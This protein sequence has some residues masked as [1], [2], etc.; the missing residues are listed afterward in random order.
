MHLVLVATIFK[1]LTKNDGSTFVHP[2][3]ETANVRQSSYSISEQS[4]TLTASA[5][6]A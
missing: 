1:L 3:V 5:E 2:V 4:F 6:S